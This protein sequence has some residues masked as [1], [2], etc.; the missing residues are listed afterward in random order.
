MDYVDLYLIHWPVPSQDLYVETYRALEKLQSDGL[1]RSIGVSNFHAHH[2]D[3]LLSE[4][5]VTPVL[6]QVE[7]HP[8]LAQSAIRRYDSEHGILTEAWA[9]LA[10]GRAT[11]DPTINTIARKYGKSAAHVVIR[12]HMQLGNVVIPKSVTPQRI[13]DNFNVFDFT[14]DGDDMARI[15]SL[16]TSER[17]GRDP[18]ND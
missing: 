5:T 4:T 8:W 13:R 10:R 3:R 12:W 11:E 9:P 7:L 18:D 16:D 17:T 15:G 14:L 2:I 1:A 6:N